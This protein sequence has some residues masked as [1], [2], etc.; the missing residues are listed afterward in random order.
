[1]KKL[2]F[3]KDN[4]DDLGIQL[5]HVPF[6][7]HAP[8]YIKPQVVDTYAKLV[9]IFPT[10]TSLARIDHTNHT[11]GR[12]LLDSTTINTAAF[13]YL[14]SKRKK[15]VGLIKDD[16]FYEKTNISKKRACSVY[17]PIH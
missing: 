8:K 17:N 5:H 7:I 4:E 9:D 3:L 12:D 15:A 10:A 6:F 14:Q 2:N 13:V 16:F 1:M 11:L